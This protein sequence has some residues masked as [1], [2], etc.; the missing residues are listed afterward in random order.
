MDFFEHQERARRRTGLLVAY[1]VVAV[2]LIIA[3]VYLAVAGV[4]FYGQGATGQGE[5]DSLWFP[6][7]FAEVSLGT[8]AVIAAGSLFK[9]AQLAGGGEVVARSLGGRPV[10][11]DTHDLRERVLLNVVEEMAIA[12]GTPVPPVFLLDQETSINAFAAGTTPQKAVITVT[13]GSLDT[14]SRD[15]LQ[16]VIAHEFSHILNGDMRLNLRLIGTLNGILLIAMVGYVLMRSSPRTY[17]SDSSE[18]RRGSNALP[19][20]GICLYLIGYVGIFF[21]HLIK[22]AV[23][24]QR[25]F[26]AD[27]SAVQF[28]RL[29]DG[30]AGALKKIGGLATGSR[31]RAPQAEEA[32]HML[33]GNGLGEPL[34][35]LMSTHP[36]LVERIR[37]IEPAFDGRF[38]RTAPIEYSPADLVDPRT[39]AERRASLA[40]A[41][42]LA[43]DAAAA[44]SSAPRAAT[45]STPTKIP[46]E[47]AAAI[48]QVGAPTVEHLDQAAA[49]LARLPAEF[50]AAVRD[51]LGAVATI[52]ALLLEPS[53]G[54][55]RR[56][57]LEYLATVA[58]P[59]ANAETLRLAA[60]VAKL[61]PEDRLPLVSLALPALKGL[62]PRQLDAFTKDVN[63]LIAADHQVTLFEYAIQRLIVRRLLGRLEHRQPPAIRYRQIAPLIPAC[64]T[65]L[66]ALAYTGTRDDRQAARALA[67]AMAELPGGGGGV[68]LLARDARGQKGLDAALDEFAAAAPLLKRSLL[69]A[70]AEC[71]G[72][73][74]HITIAEGELLRI[75][76][77]ALDCPMPPLKGYRLEP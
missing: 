58:D 73:D 34:F 8:L 42:A 31:L 56:G 60:H 53:D 75:I 30:I 21:G 6:D 32:S 64:S 66:S 27:A 57:Q 48:A 70:C 44:A 19:L 7:L 38:Q 71:I 61:K 63:F 62:S 14:L 37:R 59:R 43:P 69:S 5:A 17:D 40:G 47:P 45:A 20:L 29:P 74:G 46:F 41:A 65:L 15:Q 67:H 68:T 26:L 72:A 51:P 76:A 55:V 13:R 36:P 52:Y 50:A 10:L 77:D 39:L 2:V 11:P 33:F 25:E 23:S 24:R 22:S 1:F 35:G 4:L 28:T 18:D 49:L 12:S 54:S 9:F 3:A 16:G